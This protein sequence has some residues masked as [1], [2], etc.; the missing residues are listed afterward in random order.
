[1][2]LP[3]DDKDHWYDRA[4]FY[5][6]VV[7]DCLASREDRK[8]QY[9]VYRMFWMWG[10]GPEDSSSSIYNYIYP[11]IDQL[12]AFTFAS[13]TT[14]FA[15]EF[16][17]TVSPIEHSKG[18]AIGKAVQDEW[19]RNGGDMCFDTAVTMG[20]VFGTSVIKMRPKVH[21]GR[22]ELEY[23]NLDPG[24]FG[25]LREDTRQLER[26][27]A[28][29]QCY[30]MTVSNLVNDLREFGEYGHDKIQEI[31]RSVSAYNRTARQTSGGINRI[32]TS[33]SQPT[34][35]GNVDFA[36][37]TID[38]YKT[39]ITRP[40]VSMKELYV[41]DDSIGDY[42]V[43]TIAD[44]NIVIWDR[45]IKRT[46][47]ERELP[48]IALTPTPLMGSFWGISE[49]E[50]LMNLQ[51]MLNDRCGQIMHLLNLH[52]RQ[53][54]NF[55]GFPGIQD[56][57]AF[58]LDSPGGFVQ[59][60]MPGAKVENLAPPLPDDLYK[61]VNRIIQMMEETAGISNVMQGKG[62]AG[63]RSSGHASQLLRVGASRVK[64]RAVRI[65]EYLENMATKTYQ[66][67][68]RYSKAEYVE[69]VEGGKR[70]IL[71]QAPEEAVIK[72]DGHS[73]SPI[74]IED[75]TQKT[76]DLLKVGAIDREEALDL[77]D[78]PMRQYM[79]WKLKNVI[80]PK[81]AAEAKAA[82][83]AEAAKHAPNVQ[84]IRR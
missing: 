56:E 13:E 63:V 21:Q 75:A 49:V 19:L 74:F 22:A 12:T 68:R 70:F 32:I 57:M 79:Q 83:A 69:E 47:V 25:V 28:C 84:P 31:E 64:K 48:F 54:R 39:T 24:D 1:M 52:A 17:G 80:E 76:F 62:E 29:V 73:N 26:Q 37:N 5:K 51:Q 11:L 55:S 33:T 2:R 30:D 34:V 15:C 16:P 14:R 82:Q 20:H 65:E 50:R 40:M 45:P 27:E 66:G 59:S 3:K 7:D 44:P 35:Q 6:E 23:Y 8:N 18:P 61:E 41:Y 81:Q 53:P 46:W 72:V 10:A 71:A 67:M 36:L 43:V 4:S 77:L 78:V 9:A 42:R 58:A 38:R 60:D